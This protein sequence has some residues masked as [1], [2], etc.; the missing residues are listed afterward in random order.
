MVSTP[1]HD[2]YD[3]THAY[4]MI[5]VAYDALAGLNVIIPELVH[6]FTSKKVLVMK[7]CPGFKVTD[8]TALEKLSLDRSAL[9]RTVC[10]SFAYQIHI[11]GVFNGDPHPGM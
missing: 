2:V 4:H 9:M 11:T 8:N 1:A 7:Y 10:Q 3:S 6:G 5:V